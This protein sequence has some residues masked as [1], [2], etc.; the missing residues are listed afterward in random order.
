MADY[1]AREIYRFA[2]LAGFSPDQ[3]VTMTAI[4]LAESGGNSNAHNSSGEDSRGLWQINLDA[5]RNWAGRWNLYDPMENAKA[6]FRVSGGGRDVSPWTVTHGANPRYVAY[7][8]EAQAAARACGDTAAVGVWTGTVG[9][10]HPLSPGHDGT[11]PPPGTIGYG[12]PAGTGPLRTFLESALAQTGDTYVFGAEAGLK[13]ANPTTFDCSELVQWSAHQAGADL[14]DGS[15]L[16]YLELERRGATISVEQAMQTP[17]ALLF[18][19]SSRP[20]TGGGRPDSAHV[21]ISLGDGKTIEARGTR[22]GVGSWPAEGRFEYG[23]VIPGIS[24]GRG[25]SLPGTPLGPGGLAVGMLAAGGLA[26]GGVDTDGDGLTDDL[27]ARIGTSPISRDTDQDNL[28]D[29]YEVLVLG[30]DPRREDTD[31]DG[32]SDGME[33]A[34]GTDPL[35]P[36]TDLDGQVDGAHLYPDGATDSDADGLTDRLELILGTD[37]F[38]T[39]SDGDGFADGA[40]Y[41]AKFNPADPAS[42]PLATQPPA[43]TPGAVPPDPGL[44]GAVPP[45]PA[46]PGAG[47]PGGSAP[48]IGTTSPVPPPDPADWGMDPDAPVV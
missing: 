44:P 38:A 9:Y 22:Y 14:P 28:S 6:A 48:R 37:P 18:S 3:S 31:R 16:Q 15:W 40:E 11:G 23:A 29:G 43:G 39:D 33:L 7:Q 1:S 10:G 46:L 42:N 32:I 13:V 12:D 21:A 26:T 2:R 41:R 19:F 45:D 24:D 4:A 36:D 5:H 27:E 25:G 47:L 17:G 8:S 35:N 30:T 34:L 20:T